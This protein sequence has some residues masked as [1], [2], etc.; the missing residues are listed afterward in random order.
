MHLGNA[1][2]LSG[3]FGSLVLLEI[4]PSLWERQDQ[5]E[6]A[7]TASSHLCKG[8]EGCETEVLAFQSVIG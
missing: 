6:A 1:D 3:L 5:Q 2:S 8:N 7:P 4:L